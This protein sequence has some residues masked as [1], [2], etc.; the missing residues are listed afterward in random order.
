MG[1]FQPSGGPHLLI[2]HLGRPTQARSTLRLSQTQP[3][4]SPLE[5]NHVCSFCG[6]DFSRS[7][8]LPSPHP[9]FPPPSALSHIYSQNGGEARLT[10]G[11][12]GYGEQHVP[13]NPERRQRIRLFQSEPTSPLPAICD[14]MKKRLCFFFFLST[15]AAQLGLAAAANS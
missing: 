8:S 9:F 12:R 4:S 13:A 7:L 5:A 6:D 1:P 10:F 14:Q 15:V 2:I 11:G 3:R